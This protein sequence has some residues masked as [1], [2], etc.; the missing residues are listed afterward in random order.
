MNEIKWRRPGRE[1]SQD[2]I[3]HVE[4]LLNYEFP[5]DYKT[6]VKHYHGCS[7]IPYCIDVNHV[8]RVF[9]RLLPFENNDDE[10]IVEMYESIKEHLGELM[11]PFAIDPSGNYFCFKSDADTSNVVFWNHEDDNV[12]F[13]CETFSDMLE[14]LHK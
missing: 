9:G 10:F 13:I 5:E 8:E 6:V 1:L 11:I 7:V 12:E 14:L 2:E 3:Q 4:K